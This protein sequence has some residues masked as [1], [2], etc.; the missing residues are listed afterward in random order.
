MTTGD[1]GITRHLDRP[2][3][4][5]L[6]AVR[7]AL[8]AQGFGVITEIDVQAT[9]REKLGQEF[10]RYVILGACNPALAHRALSADLSVGLLLPC[11]V[12]VYEDAD[13]AGSTVTAFD[14]EVGMAMMP[15][16]AIASVASEAKTRLA[17]ALDALEG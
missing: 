16:G 1:F 11:N 9:L 12:V 8:K 7:D 14:P 3:E 10:R 5:A 15:E 6:A 13:G 2:Y 17:A 4:E